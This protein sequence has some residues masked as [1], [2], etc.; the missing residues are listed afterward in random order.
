MCLLKTGDLV[1]LIHSSGDFEE[2][3]IKNP[4]VYQFYMTKEGNI[5]SSY[6]KDEE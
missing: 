4:E 6:R 1:D 5:G 2:F 3:E